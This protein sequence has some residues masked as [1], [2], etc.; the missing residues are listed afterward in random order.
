V[1][2]GATASTTEALEGW[3]SGSSI[4]ERSVALNGSI[5]KLFLVQIMWILKHAA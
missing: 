3:E 1:S 2:G 4:L 5:P